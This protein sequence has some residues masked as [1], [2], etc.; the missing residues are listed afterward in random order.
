MTK[1]AA[2]EFR[3]LSDLE[4]VAAG[5]V[6]PK[7][8]S[9][10]ESGAGAGWTERANR[11]AFDRWTA[12]PRALAGV[13]EID[14]STRILG[15]EVRAPVFV[16]PTAYQGLVHPDGEVGTARAAARAGLLA[17]FSTLSTR[18]LEEVSAAR[19]IGP[20]WFQLY[21]QPEWSGTALLVRRAER[22]GFSAIVLTVDVPV[23]GVRDAQLRTGFAIDETIPVGSGP[24]IAMPP[25]R[26]EPAGEKWTLG[27]G[28]A[29]SWE[30]MDRLHETTRLPIVVKGI[31]TAADAR[32]AVDYGARAVIVSNHGG[33]QLD[34]A[35]ASLSA[36]PEVVAAVGGG[37]EVY[38]DGGV[39]RGSDILIALALGARAVG[40]GRPV[41]WALGAGGE[42]GVSKYLSLLASDL[43][44]AM[45]LAGRSAVPEVDRTVVAPNPA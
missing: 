9:Y 19:P 5:R 2:A 28:T 45:A 25:R 24:E 3:S 44:T 8:W 15:T 20:R 33:R 35:P 23:L 31:L 36:L 41:L 21:L 32:R 7:V 37:T 30:V 39:R 34:R 22:A 16:A 1:R 43:A 42:A 17:V 18:S 40:V 11:T 12:L 14:L 38:L 6:S 29:E 26:P 13:R 4:E 27:R 10:I